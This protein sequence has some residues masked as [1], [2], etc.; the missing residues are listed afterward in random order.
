MNR[1]KVLIFPI[2]KKLYEN[3]PIYPVKASAS[4]KKGE[5]NQEMPSVKEEISGEALE[6]DLALPKEKVS[7]IIPEAIPGNT[8]ENALKDIPE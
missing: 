2:P 3:R 8:S 1:N 5:D 7:E 6:Q 4:T